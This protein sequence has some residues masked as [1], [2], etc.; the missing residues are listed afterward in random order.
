M[1][2]HGR[3]AVVT[4]GAVRLGRALSLM[5]GEAGARVAVHYDRSRD[6]AER[7][8]TD[9]RAG[10]S[11]AVTVQADLSHPVTAAETIV[12]TVT[13]S[14][15]RIDILINNAAIFEPG[16]LQGTTPDNWDRH[17]QINLQAPVFLCRRV[18]EQ[19]PSDGVGAIINIVDWRAL[20]P[21]PGHLA[22]TLSKAGL[23]CLTKILAQELA[24]RIRVNA[25]APGAM[26]PAPNDD[27]ERFAQMAGV[28]PLQ[29]TGEPGDIAAAA[30]YLLEN[31]FVTGE[32]L[33]VTGGQ[34]L[35]IAAVSPELP[36]RPRAND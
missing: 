16:S 22:Y 5:L 12:A 32:V 28:I 4:G 34:E 29:R 13:Q 15:G 30:R 11:D 36:A 23:V 14:L 26:L 17:Q 8:A 7:T 3:V 10:G 21:Q 6:A 35:T 27:G 2:L 19:I 25:I 24:P 33:H 20:R 1:E 18:A 9:I 31:D